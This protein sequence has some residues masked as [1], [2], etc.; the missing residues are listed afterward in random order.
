M[1]RKLQNA[2]QAYDKEHGQEHNTTP[3]LQA[4]QLK[5]AM[6]TS[7]QQIWQ[8]GL[9]AFAAARGEGGDLFARLMKEGVGLQARTQQLAWQK[10][11]DAVALMTGTI[12]RQAAGPLLRMEE[13]FEERVTRT[14]RN[15]GVPTQDDLKALTDEIDVLR[16]TIT[17][18]S[19]GGARGK[20]TAAQTK[21]KTMAK[22]AAR[23]APARGVR[24]KTAK[25]ATEGLA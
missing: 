19:N 17:A 25:M 20:K 22:P 13:V 23:R 9:G 16:K 18:L 5:D 10:I 1:T 4:M 8:A 24:K 7:A 2:E 6:R 15:C 21:D 12:G 14:L 3:D 11:S